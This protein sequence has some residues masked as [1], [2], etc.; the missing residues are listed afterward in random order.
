[1]SGQVD[2][3]GIDA[4]ADAGVGMLINVRPDGEAPGQPPADAMATHA[5]AQGL[6]YAHIPVTMDRITR[7][8]IDAFGEAFRSTDGP[9]HAHCKSGL[10]AALLWGLDQVLNEGASA[11]A[12]VGAIHAA[13]FDPTVML[14]WLERHGRS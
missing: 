5:E 12:T 10:R 2:A 1:M 4:L 7:A 9:V 13:G 11:D 14:V 3:R 8:D 6:R